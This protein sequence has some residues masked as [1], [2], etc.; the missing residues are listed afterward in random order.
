MASPTAATIAGVVDRRRAELHDRLQSAV[1]AAVPDFK[2]T[3]PEADDRARVLRDAI[4]D[5]EI[6][7]LR[8]GTVPPLGF[9][10]ELGESMARAGLPLDHHYAAHRVSYPILLDV[11]LEEADRRGASSA[12][13]RTLARRH[14][15]YTTATTEAYV[16]AYVEAQ[17]LT[18]LEEEGATRRFLDAMSQ[19]VG[20]W[21]STLRR[22]AASFGIDPDTG[23]FAVIVSWAELPGDITPEQLQRRITAW[24]SLADVR[25]ILAAGSTV[26]GLVVG[27]AAQQDRVRETLRRAVAELDRDGVTSPRIGISACRPARYAGE[28]YEQAAVAHTAT[29]PTEPCRLLRDVGAVD[30]LV[31]VSSPSATHLA[32]DGA[33]RLHATTDTTSPTCREVLDSWVDHDGNL[34]ATAAALHCHPNTVLNRFRRIRALS[35]LDPR[36]PAG[37]LRLLV[38]LALL[39]RHHGRL[40]NPA[41]GIEPAPAGLDQPS[42][43]QSRSP[44]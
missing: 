36:A 39:D 40:D 8:T 18:S 11:V 35:G 44:R 21:S 38:D 19:S 43:S 5:A 37:L 9:M 22:V 3:D 13:C 31:A 4:I 24:L 28:L 30:Y 16:A 1:E 14:H 27:S 42:A 29:T 17:Q 20:A 6:E 15:E 32:S 34:R 41:D 7:S 25:P 23:S 12:L 26:E 10:G 33:R 2:F